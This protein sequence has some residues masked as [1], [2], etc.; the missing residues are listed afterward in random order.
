MDMK[1]IPTSE[2]LPEAIGNYLVTANIRSKT[3]HDFTYTFVMIDH[4]NGC[5]R[6]AENNSSYKKVIAWMNIP[7]KYEEYER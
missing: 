5:G 6:W 4:Y 1:W 2:K 3:N 7:D